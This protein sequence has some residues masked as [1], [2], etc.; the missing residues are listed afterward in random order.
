MALTPTG[1]KGVVGIVIEPASASGE[2]SLLVPTAVIA[3]M[4]GIASPTGST[5]AKLHLILKY[6][7]TSGSL[8]ING[9]GTPSGTETISVPAPSAQQ[10]QSAQAWEYVSVN[11]YT[12]I[13][14]ITTTGLTNGVLEVRGDAAAKF[15]IPVTKFSTKRKPGIYS[16]SEYNGLMARDKKLIQALTATSIDSFD[17]DFYGD[18]SLYW[19]YLMLGI[20]TWVTLPAAPL[21]IVASATLTATLTIANQ[22]SAPRMRLIL[23]V[24]TF[25]GNPSITING[26]SYGL[27]VSETITPSGNGTYYSA[28]LYSSITSI[29]SAVNATTVAITGVYGWLGTVNGEATRQTANEEF[30]DGEGSWVHPFSYFTDG[31]M[32]ISTKDVAKLTLKGMCQDKMLIGDRTTNPLNTNRTT[33]IAASLVDIP[34]AGWETQVYLDDITGTAGTTVYLD[35]EEEIKIALKTPVEARFTFNNTQNFTRAREGKRECT[36]DLTTDIINSLQHE[37]FRQ[38][39][40]QYLVIKLLGEY[41]GTTAGTAYNKGWWWTLP[42]QYEEYPQEGNPEKG[43]VQAK[44]KLRTRYD[45]GIGSSYQ[46]QIVTTNPPTYNA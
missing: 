36:I 21:S 45:P 2:Q 15:N 28:N 18:L 44:P 12:A 16:P 26:T 13:T 22:P 8:T 33:S 10:L 27:T 14:N 32:I 40:S 30:Y 4:T 7:T 35:P 5:G 19:V 25:T 38:N 6:W 43:N 24:S 46:L 23:A 31:E 1:A 11:N 20:P 37:Y 42:L 17:S 39:L 41:I 29:T 3:T 9:T 34:V